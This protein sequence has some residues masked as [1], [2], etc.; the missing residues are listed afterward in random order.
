MKISAIV[1]AAG[2]GTRMKSKKPKVI[3]EILG[4]PLLQY[5]IDA[6]KNAGID[7]IITVLGFEKDLVEP[8]VKGS[9]IVIQEKRL[10]TGDAV[11]AAREKLLGKSDITVIVYGDCPLVTPSTI[12]RM[13]EYKD[14]SRV[15][16]VVLSM[17]LENPFGYGR[18]VRDERGKVLRNIEEKDASSQEKEIKECNAGFYCTDTTLLFDALAKVTNS[19]SQGEYYLTDIIEILNEEGH[20]VDALCLDDETETLGVNSRDQLAYA[21]SILQ[22][23]INNLHMKNG[24]TIHDPNTTYIGIDVEIEKDVEILPN[25]ILMGNTSIGED[26]IVGPNSRLYNLKV[27][28]GCVVDE[29]IAYDS[30]LEDGATTG[31]R[32]YLRP[33]SHL[34]K[35]AKAGTCVEIKKSTIGEGSKVPHLSYI[36]DTEIGSGVNLGAGTITCNYDGKNKNK[37]IIGD[38]SFIGSSTMLVAPVNLGNNVL[39]GAGSVITEDIP[40]DTLAFGRARQVNKVGR[41]KKN[42]N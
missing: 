20:S 42:I 26:S 33:N 9:E 13:I 34:C 35:N 6:C 18:I 8:Y 5:P 17:K 31:P 37:T 1:L 36:G 2:S 15:D 41:N 12:K 32:C 11:N 19:N 40:D 24:I 21:S 14:S 28:R 23:R 10:G 3:H 30:I 16:C 27:G 39:V 38:D 4:K 25:C 7:N 22:K 29:T